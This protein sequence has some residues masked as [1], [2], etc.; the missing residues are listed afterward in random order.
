MKTTR[1]GRQYMNRRVSAG[2]QG[3]EHGWQGWAGLL[4]GRARQ[5]P[6][7]PPPPPR[8]A[9]G[10]FNRSLPTEQTNQKGAVEW[11]RR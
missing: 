10:G 6:R 4:C 3:C 2:G 7:P 8:A 9:Q 11:L 5:K 1:A